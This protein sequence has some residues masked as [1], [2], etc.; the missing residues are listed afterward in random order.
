MEAKQQVGTT[1]SAA[2]TEPLDRQLTERYADCLDAH[3]ETILTVPEPCM[4]M[5]EYAS[6]IEGAI[7]GAYTHCLVKRGPFLVVKWIR[8]HE[9]NWL[10]DA[11]GTP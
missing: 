2:M 4:T 7:A 6:H 5:N 10:F 9:V 11:Y 1:R 8:S 3:P